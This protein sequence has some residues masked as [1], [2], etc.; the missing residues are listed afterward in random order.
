MSEAYWKVSDVQR[1]R[2]VLGPRWTEIQLRSKASSVPGEA[3]CFVYYFHTPEIFIFPR[4]VNYFLQV[5]KPN[6]IQM[7]TELKYYFSF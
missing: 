6:A 7:K 3:G 5:R 4:D 1:K 2:L